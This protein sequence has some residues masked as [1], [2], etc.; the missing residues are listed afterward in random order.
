MYEGQSLYQLPVTGGECSVVVQPNVNYDSVLPAD[1]QFD[2]LIKNI[3]N[4]EIIAPV[5][6]GDQVA[7]ISLWYRNSCVAE[8]KLYAMS[9]VQLAT[10]VSAQA[11]I[12]GVDDGSSGVTS[13]IMTVCLGIQIGRASCRERV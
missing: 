5:K 12:A 8:A 3:T 9:D 4:S 13:V 10:G 2:N 11:G 1:C 7:T 6:E